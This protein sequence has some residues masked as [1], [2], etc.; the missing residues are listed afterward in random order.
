MIAAIEGSSPDVWPV[1]APYQT[2]SNADHWEELTGLPVWKYYEWLITR[3]DG[4]HAEINGLINEALPFDIVQPAFPC[5]DDYSKNT[6]IALRDGKAYYRDKRSG[7]FSPVPDEIHNAGSGGGE[8]ETR[9]VYTF[10]DARARIRA[11]KAERLVSNG[12]NR[13]LDITLG[14]FGSERFIVSG[15]VVSPFYSNAYHVGM[16]NM[17]AMLHDEPQ[18]IKYISNLVLEQ[19]IELIRAYAA[20]SGDAIFVDDATATSDMISPAMYEEFALPYLREQVS[21]IKRQ[22]FKAIAL[23]FGGISD[24]AE[25]IASSGA[26]ALMMECSMKSYVNDYADIASKLGKNICLAGNLN[27]YADVEISTSEELREKITA[28]VKAGA[29]HGRY[30]TS[31]GSPLTPNTSVR[32]MREYI[33]AA[34]FLGANR[35]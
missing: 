21:E 4:W 7:D 34:H 27:P 10:A 19:N 12:F 32:R 9:Y 29:A 2:L 8:N 35:P 1:A 14:Q 25:L 22:G 5:L 28:I 16:T 11:T 31:T 24:R 3:N 18:L 15:G 23:Y 20:A 6:E 30:F 26:D 13:F 17:Y 33:D